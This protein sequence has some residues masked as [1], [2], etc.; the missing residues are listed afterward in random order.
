MTNNN[1]IF[2]LLIILIA[3]LTFSSCKSEYDQLVKSEL[4]SGLQ[5]DSLI[6]N[7][8]LGEKKS[9]FFSKC[10]ELNK[11]QIISQGS[12][13]KYARF[14]EP[15]DSSNLNKLRKQ[16]DFFGI[17][18]Q[19]QIMRGMEMIFQYLAWSPWNENVQ[20]DALLEVL[21][22]EFESRYPGNSFIS[23]EVK[24]ANKTAYIKVDGNMQILMFQQGDKEVMVK[25]EDLN[26]KLKN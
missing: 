13:N 25:M 23:V 6:F 4:S 8:F 18:D 14:I 5:K 22:Q 26:Y 10:W 17:F 21:R 9:E 7:M 15:I 3:T 11:Q 20:G 24:E 1:S 2:G 12:G 16:I 19:Q